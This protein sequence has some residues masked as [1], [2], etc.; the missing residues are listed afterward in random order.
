[1]GDDDMTYQLV[2]ATLKPIWRDSDPGD[3]YPEEVKP[4]LVTDVIAQKLV[5][6]AKKRMDMLSPVASGIDYGN[7]IL[8][9]PGDLKGLCF[10][11]ADEF[12]QYFRKQGIDAKA[13]RVTPKGVGGDHYFTVVNQGNE[14]NSFIVDATWRQFHCNGH[15][16]RYCL[17]GTMEIVNKA[18]SMADPTD[19]I[20]GMYAAGIK[21]LKTWKNYSCF[22]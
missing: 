11:A 22:P 21:V 6:C 7:L 3:V 16:L 12:E 4:G 19:D 18:L 2:K 1:M 10:V 8:S 20:S 9:T 17:V 15:Q 13:V 14:K 5:S